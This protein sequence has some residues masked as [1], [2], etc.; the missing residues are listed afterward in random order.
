MEATN[1][2]GI[3]VLVDVDDRDGPLAIPKHDVLMSLA[4]GA[5]WIV[6]CGDLQVSQ[7]DPYPYSRA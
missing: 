4:F 5:K 3:D 2:L 6:S 1:G 7:Y